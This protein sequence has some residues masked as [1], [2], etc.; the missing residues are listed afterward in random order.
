MDQA[1]Q[2]IG[3]L[4]REI[5]PPE[6]GT[7]S[8]TIHQDDTLKA[9]LFGFAAGQELSEHTAAMPAIM[10]FLSG[11]AD[12]TLGSDRIA[13]AP[14]CWV[15]MPPHTPHSIQARTPLVMLLLLLKLGAA[16]S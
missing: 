15:H 3:N 5:D 11:E 12:V 7:L 14:G 4:V 8:R 1:F 13:A 16:N 10:H 2:V 9:V 6:D